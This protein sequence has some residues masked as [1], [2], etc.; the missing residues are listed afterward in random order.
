MGIRLPVTSV[1]PGPTVSRSLNMSLSSN[2]LAWDEL[3]VGPVQEWP[4]RSHRH[5]FENGLLIVGKKD[6]NYRHWGRIVIN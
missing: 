1:H 3:I 5:R 6:C 4:A 2:L